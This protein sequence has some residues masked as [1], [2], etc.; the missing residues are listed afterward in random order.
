[1]WAAD[2]VA[3]CSA[4]GNQLLPMTIPDGNSG[5]IVTWYDPR[6]GDNDIYAQKVSHDGIPQWKID[7]V[8]LCA[9]AGDQDHPKIISNTA[10]GAIATWYDYRNGEFPDI[11]AQQVSDDGSVQWL[12]DG[13]AICLAN[14]YQIEPYIAED[15]EG[16]GIITWYDNRSG[17]ND[18]FAQ[19]ISATGVVQWTDNGIEVC[20]ADDRQIFPTIAPSGTGMAIVT[21][22]DGRGI[23]VGPDHIY[24]QRVPLN[25]ELSGV[26]VASSLFLECYPN[27]FN[28]LINIRFEIQ[29]YGPVRIE[30]YDIRGRRIAEL[31]DQQYHVGEH[32]VEWRGRDSSGRAAPSGE[33]FFRVEM[34]GQV[35]T[36]KAMLLR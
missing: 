11:Y 7:G 15:G 22:Q 31:T 3:L 24:A 32:S 1:M 30:V 23:G 21:W 26:I 25:S 27:P 10:G 20:S 18:I 5:G 4:P 6:G 33:Y 2:G 17:I 28:P 34:D 14:G 12:N 36:R 16:G 35:E 29:G 8:V 13:V 19:R 9:A